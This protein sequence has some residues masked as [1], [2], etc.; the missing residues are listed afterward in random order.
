MPKKS[1]KPLSCGL[2][3]VR[4][5]IGKVD[6]KPKYKS[7]YGKTQKEANKKADDLRRKI[8]D[9][10]DVMREDDTF[11]VWADKWLENQEA[12]VSEKD[13]QTY[14]G[15][16]NRW[17]ALDEK[18][19]RDIKQQDIQDIIN[20]YSRRNPFTG[21]PTAKRTLNG[22]LNAINQIFY[23]AVKNR[24]IQFNP[25]K[26]VTIPITAP[27]STRRALTKEEQQ[28]ILDTPHQA[29]RAAIIMMYSGLRRS[30]LIPLTWND[31]NFDEKTISVNKSANLFGSKTN[32]KNAGKTAT[33]IRTVNV[34][35]KLVNYLRDER[36]SDINNN[37]F[38]FLVFP[39]KNGKIMNADSWRR[40]WDSYLLTLNAK[41]GKTQPIEE[42][43]TRSKLSVLSIPNITG[44]WMRHTFA[45]ML[46]LAGVDVLT[47]K[48]Q[49]GHRHV[50][51]TLKIY[52]HLD[53]IYKKKNINKLDEYLEENA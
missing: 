15:Y 6:G 24:V 37:C 7:V 53:Q 13:Y 18:P 17:A 28:W 4:I 32:I 1:N 22:Y 29:Q 41:Y 25:V 8:R 11:K 44:H 40:M 35:N 12:R 31:I 9:G 43:T 46:Y 3:R 36:Q 48:E 23:L 45:T 34:P 30:E 39:D 33:S 50:E 49:L 27:K 52:T 2:Y 21:N 26:D 16:R 51:T 19:L 42:K 14:S 10:F 5:Y 38:N 47:A 20:D